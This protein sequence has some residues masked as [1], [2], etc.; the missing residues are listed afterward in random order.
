M[1]RIAFAL[2]ILALSQADAAQPESW[3][4]SCIGSGSPRAWTNT[5]APNMS[6]GAFQFTLQDGTEVRTT[7]GMNCY[8]VRT[9]AKVG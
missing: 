4:V 2:F 7:A 6:G 3:T 8:A 9:P 5:T 1:L